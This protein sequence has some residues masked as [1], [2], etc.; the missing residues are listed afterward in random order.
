MCGIY[1]DIVGGHRRRYS[2]DIHADENCLLVINNRNFIKYTSFV[3]VSYTHLDVYKRQELTSAMRASRVGTI[4]NDYFLF[5][6]SNY[7]NVQIYHII[8]GNRDSTVARNNCTSE[9]VSHF[10]YFICE[11]G[12]INRK[13]RR[14]I[15]VIGRRDVFVRGWDVLC[16]TF[17]PSPWS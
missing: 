9:Q 12:F 17:I 14:W 15:T 13:K 8:Y 6:F 11:V 7:P 2:G 10:K 3:S 5:R 1:K 16:N 4:V